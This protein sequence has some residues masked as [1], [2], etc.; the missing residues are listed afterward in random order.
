MSETDL[1]YNHDV[2]LASYCYGLLL[3]DVVLAGRAVLVDLPHVVV[4]GVDVN[5][6]V[7]CRGRYLVIIVINFNVW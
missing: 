1:Y 6:Q 3:P 4:G 7:G 5:S 2:V